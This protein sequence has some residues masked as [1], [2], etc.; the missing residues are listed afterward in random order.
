MCGTAR[1][2]GTAMMCGTARMYGMTR[3]E[4]DSHDRI[5]V[6]DYLHKIRE[7]HQPR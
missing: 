7:Q 4:W 3:N 2:Y 5:A 6:I 1:M